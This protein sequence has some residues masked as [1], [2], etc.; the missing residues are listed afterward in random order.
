M[1]I[2]FLIT[3]ETLLEMRFF[4]TITQFFMMIILLL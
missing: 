3:I 2:F 4:M 1:K